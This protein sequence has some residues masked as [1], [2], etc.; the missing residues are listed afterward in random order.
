MT[1]IKK[2]ARNGRRLARNNQSA[3]DTA[4]AGGEMLHASGEVISARLEIMAA[5][6]ANPGKADLAEISLMSSEKVEAIS[7][8]VSTVTRNFGD[9]SDRLTRS[10]ANE[11]HLASRAA[12]AMASATDPAALATLQYNYAVGWWGRATGQMLTL[13]TELLKVQAEAL[14]P[15][16][17]TAVANAKRLKR[18]GT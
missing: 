9:L 7:A 13:N 8:S 11:I 6:L 18:P 15:I 10:A 3:A 4:V 2:A 17:R 5:G 1:H 12:A 16:H 14:D